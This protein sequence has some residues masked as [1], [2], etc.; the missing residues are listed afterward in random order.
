VAVTGGEGG[1]REAFLRMAAGL[2]EPQRGAVRLGP[3]HLADANLD[4]DVHV[5]AAT[6]TALS[7]TVPV[8][9]WAGTNVD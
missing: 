3:D 8:T 2:A 1:A 7:S 6:V 5:N 4:G 9:F